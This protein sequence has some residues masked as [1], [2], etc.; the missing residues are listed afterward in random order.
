MRPLDGADESELFARAGLPTALLPAARRSIAEPAFV[1]AVWDPAVQWHP[2]DLDAPAA[3][4]DWLRLPTGELLAR[5]PLLG[6]VGHAASIRRLIRA[7]EQ[8]AVR[9][10]VGQRAFVEVFEQPPG[11][12]GQS[13][14]ID[15][16]MLVSDAPAEL[17]RAGARWL[18]MTAVAFGR[19]WREILR[20]RL[21]RRL[22]SALALTGNARNR[23]DARLAID[24]ILPRVERMLAAH[25]QALDAAAG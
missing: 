19:G 4:R 25:R 24:E 1:H 18:S 11:E 22:E 8:Q 6:L 13:E 14:G 7:R 5:L 20:L 23:D 21:P 2:G 3:L 12:H 16:A 15:A 17:E 10:A 9:D